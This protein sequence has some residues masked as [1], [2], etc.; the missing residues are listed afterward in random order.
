[1]RR[2]R[3]VPQGASQAAFERLSVAVVLSATLHVYV[4]YGLAPQPTQRATDRVSIISARLL[5]EPARQK[6]PT[7][8]APAMKR[9]LIPPQPHVSSVPVP[10]E[11][12]VPAAQQPQAEDPSPAPEVSTASLPDPFHYAARELDVYP[13]PLNRIEPTYPQTALSG[14]IGGSVTLLVLI[15]ESG[16]VT[17]VSVVDA[18]P[19]DVF[20]ESALHALAVTAY[21]PA[22]KGAR[23]VRSRILLK[24]DYDPFAAAAT[25]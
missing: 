16:R 3:Q 6:R 25:Q 8:A 10:I 18:S 14:G 12:P 1:M 24:I 22:Q 15:D 21:S 5:P 7:L 13:Q 11:I 19:Q 23:A 2:I 17:D 20:D 4:I 9:N